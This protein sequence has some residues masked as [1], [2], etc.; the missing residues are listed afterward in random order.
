[1]ENEKEDDIEKYKN[2]MQEIEDPGSYAFLIFPICVGI[3][4]I[5]LFI[6]LAVMA[7]SLEGYELMILG[8]LLIIFIPIILTI[9]FFSRRFYSIEGRKKFLLS[10]EKFLIKVPLKP[11]IEIKWSDFDELLIT[12]RKKYGQDYIVL[13]IQFLRQVEFNNIKKVKYRLHKS[14][15][16]RKIIDL[17]S[18]YAT[19]KNVLVKIDKKDL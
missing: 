9:V 14:E 18:S 11:I 4:I 12:T 5:P 13:E 19:L 15:N 6:F 10:N 2:D 7:F 1:M 16:V 8:I 3:F 17:I